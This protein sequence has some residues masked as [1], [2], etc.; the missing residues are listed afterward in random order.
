MK[1]LFYLNLLL[2][3][4]SVAI[5][6]NSCKRTFGDLNNPTIEKYLENA[7]QQQL[8]NLVSGTASGA[9]NS[10][11]LYLD[12][13]GVIGREIYRFG[14]PRYTTELLG[15]DENTLLN[16]N[17]YI[18]LNW[19]ARYRV[20]KNTNVLIEAA[21][22]SSFI[23]GEQRKG[24]LGFA[25]TFK[26]HELL[27]NL[28][29]TYRNGIRVDV[30]DADQLGPVLNHENSLAAIAAL[31]DEAK[32]DLEG[33]SI[34][35]TLSP[36]FNGFQDAAGLVKFNRALAA[37]VAVY[38][39]DWAAAQAA[40]NAS[41]L[42]INGNLYVGVSH[43]FGTGT[44]DQLNGS[45]T[46]Q[47]QNGDVRLAH[48]SYATDIEGN[49]DRI[50]KTHVRNAAASLNGLSSNRDVWVYTSGT[51]PV[52]LIRNE[53]LILLYAEV[54]IQT[55]DFPE[56]LKA[57]DKIRQAHQLLPYSGIA[58]KEA[59]ISELLRQRRYSLFFEGHRWIDVRRY[60]RLNQLPLDRP[61]DDVWEQ[62][63]L[64]VSETLK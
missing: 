16:S 39:Q 40:L 61:A 63:P 41:F 5:G 32:A 9:R 36:G 30:S 34:A 8:N 49:D 13:T 2:L 21:T 51:A 10:I 7:S 4:L 45:F 56:A 50:T 14:D 53:E 31:L 24:Y 29:L 46:P 18:T 59:L 54:K 11:D 3:M 1:T 15:A 44:G 17:F 26:A 27:L 52:Y 42:D 58:E 64:P 47:N 48:S 37:R 23:T 25:K 22:R 57:L 43:V 6:L 62:L 19:A 28:N 20:V 55:N 60:H 38:R 12:V 35:F 33:A